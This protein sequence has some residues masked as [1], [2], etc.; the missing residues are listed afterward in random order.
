MLADG[1]IGTS[2]NAGGRGNRCAMRNAVHASSS[3]T[4]IA[5]SLIPFGT[6]SYSLCRHRSPFALRPSLFALR[7]TVAF[8]RAV[9]FS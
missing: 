1:F 5:R 9:V 4:T 3:A 2:A 6:L 8:E 7:I